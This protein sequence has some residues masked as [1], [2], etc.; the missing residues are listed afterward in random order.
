MPVQVDRLGLP[1]LLEE[2]MRE[3]EPLIARTRLAVHHDVSR[4]VPEIE[5]D[6]QKVKQI[7]L[8]LLSNALKFTPEG[9]V[10]IRGAYH[11]EQERIAVAVA[12][13][14]IGISEESQ[15]NIFEAFLQADSSYARRQGGT[16][17]GLS[18]CRRLA[19][20]LDGDITLE[21]RLG[22]GSVFTLWLPRRPRRS[23]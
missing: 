12:D 22:E 8:N 5:S 15:K 14:G 11:R 18:I 3:V 19:S 9:S 6:R 1:E 2:V 16:G 20:L 4:D 10:S 13:T 21:S 17:L 7:I 23:R